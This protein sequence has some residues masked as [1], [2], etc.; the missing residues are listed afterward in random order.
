M[1][2]KKAGHTGV[3]INAGSAT[4]KQHM[5]KAMRYE[6]A[7]VSVDS[8]KRALDLALVMVR[9]EESGKNLPDRFRKEKSELASYM[10]ETVES[11]SRDILQ[12]PDLESKT[13]WKNHG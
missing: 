11:L 10:M 6:L 12:V 3:D 5:V 1:E 8:L 9:S 2:G 7:K 4:T 13:K